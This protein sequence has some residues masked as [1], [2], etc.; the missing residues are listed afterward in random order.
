M[1]TI[2]ACRTLHDGVVTSQAILTTD[3]MP[4]CPWAVQTHRGIQLMAH[5]QLHQIIERP[6]NDFSTPIIA[7]C[8]N[9]YAP[10]LFMRQVSV[11]AESGPYE[12]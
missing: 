10:A 5:T 9:S 3:V 11:A 7:M 8:I 2:S 12:T 1:Q 4:T 6:C